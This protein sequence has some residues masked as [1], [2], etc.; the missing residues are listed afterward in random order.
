MMQ[1]KYP[2]I[3][4]PHVQR[5]LVKRREL[6][7]FCEIVGGREVAVAFDEHAAEYEHR[8]VRRRNLCHSLR[9]GSF[10]VRAADEVAAGLGSRGAFADVGKISR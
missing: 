3:R 7:L 1:F 6:Y 9:Y 8:I 5:L 2:I 4:S 10:P